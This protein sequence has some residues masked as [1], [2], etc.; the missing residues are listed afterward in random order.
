MNTHYLLG[1]DVAKHKVQCCLANPN[2]QPLAR[3]SVPTDRLGLQRLVD[4]LRPHTDPAHTLVLIEATGLLHVPW[5]EALGALGA[6]VLVIN[7]LITKRLPAIAN[8]LRQHKTDRID[9][10]ALCEIGRLHAHQLQ[11]FRYRPDPQ[12]FGWQR[13]HSV[14]QQLRRSLTNLKKCYASLLDVV[15][16][17]LSALVAIH[18]RGVRTLLATASTP[19]AI[20]RQPMRTLQ[21]TFGDQA[22]AVLAAARAPISAPELA[23]STAAALR[24]ALEGI[25]QLE[26]QIKTL[27]VELLAA[28]AR[29]VDPQQWALAATVPGIG[30]KTATTLL[31]HLPSDWKQWGG[32][33]TTAAKLQ[34][35]IGIDPRLQESGQW[36][37]Q[38]KMSKRGSRSLRTALFQAAF[39]ATL[40]DTELRAYYDRK[41]AA[42]KEHKVAISHVMRIQL[43]RLVA[44]L[45]TEKPYEVC[46]AG[47]ADA[48]S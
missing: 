24:A 41:R 14:R 33:R 21:K 39:C 30:C 29:R 26:A 45:K 3:A 15:F 35:F 48:L 32:R 18:N 43:R 5:A 20:L 47:K 40:H 37:G 7:P 6:T 4:T 11:R 46:Y 17:E 27:D 12:R 9:A 13:L 44:V 2:G 23:D 16:P 10:L 31:G 8:V 19:A 36:T 25:E 34:A 38:A 28:L 22:D 1:I 42:G